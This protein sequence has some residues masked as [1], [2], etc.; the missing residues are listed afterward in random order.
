VCV[1]VW[2]LS[3]LTCSGTSPLVRLCCL[4]CTSNVCSRS[5]IPTVRSY[6]Q[7]NLSSILQIFLHVRCFL[8]TTVSGTCLLWPPYADL[9]IMR[10][11]CTSRPGESSRR[12]C[13]LQ[14]REKLLHD[15]LVWYI[16]HPSPPLLASLFMRIASSS[17]RCGRG[18]VGGSGRAPRQDVH[19]HTVR[20]EDQPRSSLR[21]GM[22]PN[23]SSSQGV[24][25]GRRR[26]HRRACSGQ[27]HSRSKKPS[28]AV[29]RSTVR[30]RGVCA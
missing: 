27:T 12:R 20:H 24:F 11:A 3:C 4:S 14:V 6:T 21:A 8:T 17:I 5:S 22:E 30:R 28:R 19:D 25:G 2:N 10:E 18:C 26:C 13:T 9:E 15:T 7:Y 16:V 1:T 29:Y 23:S